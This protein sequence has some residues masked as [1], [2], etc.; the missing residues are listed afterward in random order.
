MWTIRRNNKATSRTR[1]AGNLDIFGFFR[2]NTV[3]V[4]WR[5]LEFNLFMI[6]MSLFQPSLED[7]VDLAGH[8]LLKIPHS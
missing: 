3:Q 4:L 5:D 1:H 7:R 2:S 8:L 6:S